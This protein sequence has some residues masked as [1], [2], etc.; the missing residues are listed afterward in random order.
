MDWMKSTVPHLDGY[1]YRTLE[2]SDDRFIEML[3]R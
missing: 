1:L 2:E 3:T